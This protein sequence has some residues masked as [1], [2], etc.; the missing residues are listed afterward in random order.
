MDFIPISIVARKMP[1]L[2]LRS[3][4]VASALRRCAC[5]LPRSGCG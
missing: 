2:S 5:F 4:K 3:A 1:R